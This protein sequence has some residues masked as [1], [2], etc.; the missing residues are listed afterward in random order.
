MKLNNKLVKATSFEDKKKLEEH[1]N[2]WAASYDTDLL[3]EMGYIVPQIALSFLEGKINKQARILDIGAGTGIVGQL[4]HAK[5]YYQLDALDFSEGIL[6]EAKLK[7]N[8]Q[9]Y[10]LQ[11]LGEPLDIPT[12][13]Y[14]LI[15][16]VGTFGPTHAPATAFSELIRITK[17]KGLI[18]FTMRENEVPTSGVFRSAMKQHEEKQ[19]WLLLEESAPFKG[20]TKSNPLLNFISFIYQVI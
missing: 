7:K 11:T 19:E 20:F 1:Y 17:K 6:A 15:I 12:N 16:G 10:F 18:L 5:G 13:S 4:L 9:S 2:S 3:D 8:Y 14:D